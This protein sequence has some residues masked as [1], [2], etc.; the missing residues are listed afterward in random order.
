MT[1]ASPRLSCVMMN[2][3]PPIPIIPTHARATSRHR[4]VRDSGHNV[5]AAHRVQIRDRMMPTTQR[6][7]TCSKEGIFARLARTC[8]SIVMTEND[9]ADMAMKISP[10]P[11]QRWAPVEKKAT[12]GWA[13]SSA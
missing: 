12:V 10:V 9:T 11:P 4:V 2:Q 5:A 1:V 3:F 6:N 13:P 7:T 8:T